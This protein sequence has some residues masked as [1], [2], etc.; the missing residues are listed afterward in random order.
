MVVDSRKDEA[1]GPLHEE[2]YRDANMHSCGQ[3]MSADHV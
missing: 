2:R 1:V 3:D